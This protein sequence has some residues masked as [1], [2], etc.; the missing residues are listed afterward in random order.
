MEYSRVLRRTIHTVS[1]KLEGADEPIVTAYGSTNQ[2]CPENLFIRWQYQREHGTWE[3][4]QVRVTGHNIRKDGSL[5]ERI[6]GRDYEVGGALV[7]DAPDWLRELVT[8]YAPTGSLL[9]P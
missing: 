3:L 1:M 2:T 6:G 4:T 8:E 9:T 5:G 7:S